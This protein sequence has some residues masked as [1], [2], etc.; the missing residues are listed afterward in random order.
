MVKDSLTESFELGLKDRLLFDWPNVQAVL[1]KTTEELNELKQSLEEGRLSQAH[2][3]GD[4]L[5]TLVQV[6]RHLKLDPA[7]ALKIANERYLK[8][9]KTMQDFV[10]EDQKDFA[11]LDLSELEVYWQKAK[12]TLKSDEIQT[13]D[14]W[15]GNY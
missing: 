2:E 7:L 15:F 14:H 8:R 12:K 9:F 6:A 11:N 5:F 4:V 1:E 3:L 10:I 13:L